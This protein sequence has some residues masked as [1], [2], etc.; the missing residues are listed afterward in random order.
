MLP[1]RYLVLFASLVAAAALASPALGAIRLVKA[2]GRV[3]AGDRAS[4]TVA[5]S[6]A[7]RCTIS[8]T[9]S[10]GRSQARGLGPKRGTRIVWTWTV[11]STTKHGRWPVMVGCGKAGTLLTT[12]TVR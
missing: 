2:P 6:P 8:V 9:Y 11:G 1:M 4:V 3:S 7:S 10:T 12:V 5:V